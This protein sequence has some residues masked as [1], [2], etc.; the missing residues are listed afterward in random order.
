MG[1][2]YIPEFEGCFI[3]VVSLFRGVC[4]C[5]EWLAFV[6]FQISR[7]LVVYICFLKAASSDMVEKI[8][9]L[10]VATCVFIR[11]ICRS[12]NNFF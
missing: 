7:G 11:A 8:G 1:L 12:G 5:V 10:Q 2:K 6:M 3:L 4:V 9:M